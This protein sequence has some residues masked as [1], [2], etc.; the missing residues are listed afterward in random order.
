LLGILFL[1]SW[2]NDPA[3]RLRNYLNSFR[4]AVEEAERNFTGG[5]GEREVLEMAK[6]Y[7]EDAKYSYDK[8]DYITGLINISYAEGLLDA[9]RM[10]G[11]SSFKWQRVE[12]PRVFVGGTFDILH[13]GHIAL[14]REASKYGR[15]F[16][17]VARNANVKRFK[18]YEPVNDEMTRLEVVSAVRYVYKAF[19]GDETDYLKSV[20]AVKP[21]LILL[22]PDQFV[23]EET[24]SRQL[25]DR[26]LEGVRIIKLRE[27]IGGFSTSSLIKKILESRC[28]C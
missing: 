14:L 4:A 23:D 8:G 26:G 25:R 13:P 10:L 6:R 7:Y 15:V 20:D 3:E 24:L 28:R 27:K 5:R 22:G 2:V 16:V 1:T 11:A 17:T 19:L 12:E 21:N 18:G 9:L